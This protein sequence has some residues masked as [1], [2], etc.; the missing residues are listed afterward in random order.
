MSPTKH[1]MKYSIY[2]SSCVVIRDIQLGCRE[3]SHSFVC[4]TVTQPPSGIDPVTISIIYMLH[5][6]GIPAATTQRYL[7][8]AAKLDECFPR[9]PGSA[10]RAPIVK[11]DQQKIVN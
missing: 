10:D 4:V 2:F 11:D 8:K 3:N 7:D 5:T 1:D 6:P 9:D